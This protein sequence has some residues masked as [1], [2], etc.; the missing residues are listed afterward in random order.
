MAACIAL[1]R[2]LIVTESI[3]ARS[4]HRSAITFFARINDAVAAEAAPRTGA[5]AGAPLAATAC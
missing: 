1:E 2:A 5:A 3:A 4:A